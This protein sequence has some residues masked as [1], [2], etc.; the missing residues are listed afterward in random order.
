[1]ISPLCFP[2][3]SPNCSSCVEYCVRQRKWQCECLL[4][5][6]W[7]IRDPKKCIGK[8]LWGLGRGNDHFYQSM[9]L[10]ANNINQQWLIHKRVYWKRKELFIK[11]KD[12]A[13]KPALTRTGAEQLSGSTSRN[14]GHEFFRT[15]MSSRCITQ[16]SDCKETGIVGE[17]EQDG[18]GVFLL[19]P[20][21]PGSLQSMGSQ[22]VGHDW[23]TSL[24]FFFPEEWWTNDA[25]PDGSYWC[26]QY[27]LSL[28]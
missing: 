7:Y 23:A 10:I 15:R 24:F 14:N 17:Q 21:E 6:I 27:L 20:E 2:A 19:G 1:M 3:S 11:S 13:K 5:K 25:R 18:E 8:V 28:E 12:K 4:Y 22:R 9:S 26:P 16:E